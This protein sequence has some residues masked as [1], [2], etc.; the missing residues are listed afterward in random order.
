MGQRANR[1]QHYGPSVER[2]KTVVGPGSRRVDAAAANDQLS[3]RLQK[4]IQMN[5]G[6][7]KP[8]RSWTSPRPLTTCG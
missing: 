7:D 5:A 2:A 8:R 4:F 6:Y 3:E 1:S